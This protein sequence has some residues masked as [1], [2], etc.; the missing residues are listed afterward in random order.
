MTN[1]TAQTR[2]RA[3]LVLLK[4][5]IH[6]VLYCIVLYRR[7]QTPESCSELNCKH[8]RPSVALMFIHIFIC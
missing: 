4:R 7:W 6:V 5:A 3:R 2:S 8:K 1:N